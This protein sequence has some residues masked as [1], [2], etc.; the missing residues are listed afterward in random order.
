MLTQTK[1]KVFNKIFCIGMNKTGTS[2]LHAAF[3]KLGIKSIH[4]GF[5]DYKTLRE[6]L[7]SASYIEKTILKN[8]KEDR[9]LLDSID[10]YEAYSDIG[11]LINRFEILD[12]QYPNSKFIYTNR[13]TL[14]WIDSRKRHVLRNIENKNKQLYESNFCNIEEEKW[15]ERKFLHLDRVKKYFRNRPN[16]L[17]IINVTE[18]D[19]YEKL[20]PFLRFEMIQEQFPE[21]NII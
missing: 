8:E 14:K 17:L 10:E 15:L 19:G 4:H 21:K 6:H 12:S 20:C 11:P 16:D 1:P 13:N 5:S 18:G 7:E 9:K 2:S 3:L